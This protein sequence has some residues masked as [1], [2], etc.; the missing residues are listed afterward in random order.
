MRSSEPGSQH[1]GRHRHLTAIRK[2]ELVDCSIC[3]DH[4][5][6][7]EKMLDGDAATGAGKAREQVFPKSAQ[8]NVSYAIDIGE[9]QRVVTALVID[10]FI[11]TPAR[12]K[13]I[14]ITCATRQQ[15]IARS[16][17]QRIV[18]FTTD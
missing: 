9:Y 4:P 5:I 13:V 18:T 7:L 12:D 11:T 10:R 2:L 15:I 3:I 16:T 8:I 17:I 14:I 6:R 1:Q